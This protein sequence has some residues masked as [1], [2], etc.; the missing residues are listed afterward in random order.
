MLA[1]KLYDENTDTSIPRCVPEKAPHHQKYNILTLQDLPAPPPLRKS[2]KHRPAPLDLSPPS[3]RQHL[4]PLDNPNA[5]EEYLFS[6]SPTSANS[7]VGMGM[8]SPAH[9]SQN[10][11]LNILDSNPPLTPI[12]PL[13]TAP[14]PSDDK[15]VGLNL[16][17]EGPDVVVPS[18]PGLPPLHA[19]EAMEGPFDEIFLELLHT[20]TSFLSEVETIEIIVREVLNP[21]GVVEANW[22]DAVTQL[23]KLHTEFVGQLG[24]G[25]R[26][27][28][29]PGV[30]KSILIWVRRTTNRD[31][32]TL[33]NLCQRTL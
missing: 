30:L 19:E 18:S 20:E 8:P 5:L 28:I 15:N 4:S 2:R 1:T 16:H 23:K 22:V 32:L 13:R 12:P 10:D 24:A 33:A 3:Q 11:L 27:G 25:D 9:Y 7:A 31:V 6:S 17:V 29:T 21:L 26:A 14:L